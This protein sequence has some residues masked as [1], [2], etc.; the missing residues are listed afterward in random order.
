[1]NTLSDYLAPDL[2]VISVGLNPSLPS[3]E[4]G[5]YFANPR[6]RFWRA[7]NAS[8]LVDQVLVPSQE[9][10]RKL[11]KDHSIGF[12]DVVKKPSANASRLRA[13]DYIKW[14]PVLREKLIRYRPCMVW[15]H[16]K[17][18]YAN[19][20]RYAESSVPNIACGL[21]NKRIGNSWVYVTPN[22]SPANAQ[23]SLS[24]LIR[25][26]QLLNRQMIKRCCQAPFKSSVE[27][28]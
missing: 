8:G 25:W 16:G 23:Y 10:M 7:F 11:L 22:S 1:M 21:Q 14:A 17:V 19:Y 2:K 3:V 24:D 18:A 15:F 12:T 26:Y 9:V 28:S 4:A 5:F 27:P 20:L 13:S 6:N